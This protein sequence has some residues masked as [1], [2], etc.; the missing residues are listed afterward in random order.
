MIKLFF[1]L[2]I[3]M[4]AIWWWYLNDRGYTIKEGLK[5]FAYIFAFNGIIV[6]FFVLMLFI[7]H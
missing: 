1:L 3:V 4:C 5:G 7:T 2:P 6:A